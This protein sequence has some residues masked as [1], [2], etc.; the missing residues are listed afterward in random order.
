MNANRGYVGYSRSVRAVEAEKEGKLPLSRAIPVVSRATGVT[1]KLARLILKGI[2]PC[3]WHHTSKNF[4][5]TSF[6]DTQVAIDEI[7]L[8]NDPLREE[9]E[10]AEFCENEFVLWMCRFPQLPTYEGHGPHQWEYYVS[11]RERFD[12]GLTPESEFAQQNRAEF[13]ARI[14][15]AANFRRWYSAL[16]RL[17]NQES[18]KI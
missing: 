3:E 6:Y 12:M 1:R 16:R 5:R 4:N 9:I 13:S 18:S 15:H 7:R 8:R 17:A 14:Q 2:G 11:I 10:E